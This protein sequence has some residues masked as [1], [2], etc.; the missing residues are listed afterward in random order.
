MNRAEDGLLQRS[1]ALASAAVAVNARPGW[2]HQYHT[3][4]S[5]FRFADEDAGELG[6]ARVEDRLV[7]PGLG[8]GLVS[9]EPAWILQVRSGRGTSGHP[10]RVQGVPYEGSV[11]RGSGALSYRRLGH[12]AQASE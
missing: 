6:P 11:A 12:Y 10:G 2:V 1:L 9:E 4:T 8:A 3:P 7:Q 5:F